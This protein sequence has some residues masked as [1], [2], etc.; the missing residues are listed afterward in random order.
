MDPQGAVSSS[1]RVGW[2]HTELK[3][4][5]V[6]RPGCSGAGSDGTSASVQP[7]SP[8]PATESPACSNT[9]PLTDVQQLL[10]QL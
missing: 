3:E 6:S 7:G 4:L 2:E 8:A 1:V 10:E 5:K 9:S